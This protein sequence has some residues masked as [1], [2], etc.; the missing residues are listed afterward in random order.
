[1]NKKQLWELVE[2]IAACVLIQAAVGLLHA[3]TGWLDWGLVQHI[4][5]LDGRE[6]YG[7][8]AL[9]VLAFALIA[10]AESR[11]KS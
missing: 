8:I 7:S 5:F 4:G 10:V 1:M 2:V 9:V 11:K 6:V 3:C